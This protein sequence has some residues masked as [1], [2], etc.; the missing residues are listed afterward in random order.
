MN[1]EPQGKIAFNYP[2]F[3]LLWI[4]TMF[5]SS[6]AWALIVARGWL[7]YEI[8][9]GSSAWVA[10]VTFSA[11]IPR[12]L[13][14]PIF[15]YLSD[16]LDRKQLLAFM[17]AIN[18]V[19]N[20]FLGI[21]VTTDASVNIKIIFLAVLAFINGSARAAQ[22]SAS[23]SLLPNLIPK[24]LLLN[25][26]AWNQAALHGSR[27]F[28]PAAIVPLLSLVNLEWAF[29]LCSAFYVVSLFTSLRISTISTGVI[30]KNL[31]FFENFIA[32]LKYVY[33]NQL[34]L[35]VMFITFLHCGLTMSFESLLP[36]LSEKTFQAEGKGF[37]YL[38][39]GVGAGSLLSVITITLISKFKING[40]IFFIFGLL[41]GVGPIIL[42]TSSNL[43]YAIF[44]SFIMGISQA[45]FMTL[46]HTIIQSNTLDEVR[47]RVG[48]VYAVHVGGIMA[49]INLFNGFLEIHLGATNLLLWGGISFIIIMLLSIKEFNLKKIYFDAW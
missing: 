14:T 16:K 2:D 18:I 30:S 35:M 9:D 5:S 19:H 42:V 45:G 10:I 24:E 4:G 13:I 37:S 36:V 17:F 23:E 8:T 47:G 34:L 46:A 22:T 31:N 28:G 40:Y 11:M 44:S 15:G 33:K 27:L 43:N 39:M 26:I 20:I 41:S 1:K 21:L 25:G 48:A 38:M 7:M 29:Y 12:V 6:S 49:I 3:R 32:G